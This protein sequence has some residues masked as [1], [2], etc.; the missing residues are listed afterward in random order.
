MCLCTQLFVLA[1]SIPADA[2]QP[3]KIPRIGQMANPTIL[4]LRIEA[5]RQGLLDLGYLS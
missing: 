3:A 4:G 2:Q 1:L 5:F